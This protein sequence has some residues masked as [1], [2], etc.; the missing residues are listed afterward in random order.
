MAKKNK[1]QNKSGSLSVSSSNTGWI[2]SPPGGSCAE[3]CNSLSLDCNSNALTTGD[4]SKK[5]VVT[6]NFQR[7]G[8]TCDKVINGNSGQPET[9]LEAANNGKSRVVC[10]KPKKSKKSA[11]CATEASA[12]GTQRLCCCGT[13]KSCSLE[14]PNE[15][16]LSFAASH[17]QNAQQYNLDIEALK[18]S[19]TFHSLYNTNVDPLGIL[20]Q[21]LWTCIDGSCCNWLANNGWSWLR[22]WCDVRVTTTQPRTTTSLPSGWVLS[23]E[24]ETCNDACGSPS[25]C[26]AAGR[27]NIYYDSAMEAA[28]QAAG[29]NCSGV[30]NSGN[31]AAPYIRIN[32]PSSV[33][34]LYRAARSGSRCD[35]DLVGTGAR[36]LCCCGTNETQC[37]L[38]PAPPVG[39]VLGEA[40][41]S[42]R[43]ACDGP[44][45]CRANMRTLIQN[46][47]LVIGV[48][49]T[50]QPSGTCKSTTTGSN[51]GIAPYARGSSS[52][53]NCLYLN[54]GKTSS[55]TVSN[56]DTTLRPICC[57]GESDTDC[58]LP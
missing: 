5:A 32:G 43:Q 16:A 26:L 54:P 31:T 20:W 23:Q 33:S 50:A 42:C 49:P 2:L 47:T 7:V 28:V 17:P 18:T 34:C 46:S 58:P 13:G 22:G 12:P 41:K 39:W 25:N 52:P 19:I 37:P 45:R 8:V 38:P 3:A 14:N 48:L 10:S 51:N 21:I 53:Y 55:C 27:D 36:L 35:R 40:T 24:N 15:A 57:C 4:M 30:T 29:Y 11:T 44:A 56:P 6:E 9:W 1:N